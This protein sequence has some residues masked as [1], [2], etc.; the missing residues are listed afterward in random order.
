MIAVDAMG[1]DYAPQET[2]QG[3]LAAAKKG[4]PLILFGNQDKIMPLLS[5][6]CSGWKSLPI[7]LVHCS[8]FVTMDD[9]PVRAILRKKDSSIIRALQAVRA[10]KAQAF[11]SAGNSGAVMAA[12]ST[13]LGRVPGVIRPAIGSFLPT[14][15]AGSLF[16][17]D[18]GANPDCKPEYLLQFAY[19]GYAYVRLIKNIAQPKIAL[20]SN[21]HE[22][23]K[24]S[25]LV[26]KAF[27]LLQKTKLE[28]IG[29]IESRDIFSG[30]ADVVVTDGFTG[31]V[32]L[33]GIQGTA[34]AVM[35]WMKEE[36]SRSLF[37]QIL[38]GCAKPIVARIKKRIDYARTG[39]A[40]LLGV[41]KAPV[42]IAHGSS[43]A[44]AITQAI[45]FAHNTV[46]QK[47]IPTF[48][49]TLKTLL[50]KNIPLA[51]VGQKPLFLRQTQ[52]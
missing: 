38:L 51:A 27:D 45:F 29:N 17:L 52:S 22:P 24:G 16:C 43:K 49:E 23:Y 32:L 40:L 7:E 4:V 6:Y 2:V 19:M 15:N 21:G 42:V 5:Y 25:F 3:A 18:L 39:G 30:R 11:V 34:N 1:G 47:I 50:M 31:N 33:K 35:D 48:N 44:L 41:N 26:R 12:A 36:A 28:F 8:D 9:D 20:L 46:Q 13:V 10:G 37:S 14:T